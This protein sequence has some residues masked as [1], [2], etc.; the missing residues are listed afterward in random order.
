VRGMRRLEKPAQG[1]LAEWLRKSPVHSFAMVEDDWRRLDR[2]EGH[3]VASDEGGVVALLPQVDGLRL[4]YGFASLEA[5]RNDF[6][7]L[8][9]RAAKAAQGEEVIRRIDL[10]FADLPNRTFVEP[11]LSACG[12]AF[13]EEW[14]EMILPEVPP[15]AA[16]PS[17]P[18][19]YRLRPLVE[20]DAEA[21]VK[22]SEVAYGGPPA[23]LARVR[24]YIATADAMRGVEAAG[25]EI[26]GAVRLSK[27][28]AATGYVDDL[29]VHPEHH[30]LGLGSALM[31]WAVAWLAGQG[32]R[33]GRLHVRTDNGPAL[34]VYRKV[35]FSVS[36]SGLSYVRPLDEAEVVKARKK[37]PGTYIK[38]GGWR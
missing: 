27:E 12:F 8:L 15:D 18:R 26:V 25:G 4:H 10:Q 9:E 7:P 29:A 28:S 32:L 38:F 22:L 24:E 35:G 17:F 14:L 5:F 11:V 3:V 34:R 30:N 21:F 1:S 37:R 33:R 31:R 2:G 16:S 19:G 36:G 6:P 13:L 20:A 23:P